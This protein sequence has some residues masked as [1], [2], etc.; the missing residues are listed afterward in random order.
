LAAAPPAV[1]YGE[2]P[3]TF[4]LDI[5]QKIFS[6]I[7]VDLVLSGDNA[8]VI[9]MAARN[10]S[11]EH[12]HKAI[13][14]GGIGAIV[15]RVSFTIAAAV[16]LHVPLIQSVG[17]LLLLMIAYKLATPVS[18]HG[19]GEPSGGHRVRAAGS[20][21]DAVQTIILADA[22][23]S[24][25]NILAVG[26]AAEGHLLLLLFGLGLSIPILL[27]GS[28]LV[29]QVM[30]HHP[31]LLILGVLVLIHSAVQ[32]FFDDEFVQDI[33]NASVPQWEILLLTA[34]ITTAVLAAV[35]MLHGG[36]AGIIEPPLA[37]S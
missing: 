19:D 8:I 2:E 32:M 10:L 14:W 7:V 23:M 1:T 26:G 21:R 13:M 25:D 35:R 33:L 11:P 22:V 6:I 4:E 9:G 34:I 36:I 12:R 5:L 29:A 17:G 18:G 37:E 15:L 27:F 24:L 30:Q 31:F 28:N 20:L 3:A 16:L